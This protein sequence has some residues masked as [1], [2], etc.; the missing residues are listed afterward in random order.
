MRRAAPV[1]AAVAG[2]GIV[3]PFFVG[4][5]PSTVL[6]LLPVSAVVGAASL[7]AFRRAPAVEP[8]W[9]GRAGRVGV[10]SA[11]AHA[12]PRPPSRA[13]AGRVAAALARVE[14]RELASSP[15]F[16]TGLGFLAM[17]YLMFAVVWADDNGS[18]WADVVALAPWMA[19]PLVGMVVVAAHRGTTRARRDGADELFD[20][21][22]VEPATRTWGLLGS[23]WVPVLAYAAFCV[24]FAITITVRSPNLY[25]SI[26]SEAVALVLSAVVLCVGGVVLGVALGRWVRF[27]LAP[28]VAVVAVGLVS[29]QLATAVGAPGWTPFQQLATAPPFGGVPPLFTDPHSWAH[30]A[31]VAARTAAVAVAAVA[32]HRRDRTVAV[33]GLAACL[34]VAGAAVAATRPMP[35]S[36]AARIAGLV[37]R[38]RDHQACRP[39]GPVQVCAYHGHEELADRVVAEITPVAAALPAATPP[40]TLRQRYPGTLDELPPEVARRLPG[41]V[42]P[43]APGELDLGYAVNPTEVRIPRFLVATW[44]VGLPSEPGPDKRPEVIAGQARGVVALWLATRGLG[45]VPTRQLTSGRTSRNGNPGEGQPDAF[46]R[47][48]VWP[49]SCGTSPVVWSAQDLSAARAVVALPEAAVMTAVHRDWDRWRD[50]ATGTDEL[51]AALGLPPV[52]PFDVVQTRSEN[53]C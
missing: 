19:H 18:H 43:A 4:A 24:V 25:G 31:W 40:V 10:G 34:L 9:S 17:T 27:P 33:A 42:P 36:S 23:A 21:C 38:P 32:R 22:P 8:G 29:I 2:V 35:A 37:S 13:A 53:P 48:Y 14:G 3:A 39:A 1:L 6:F 20:T 51:L 41:G 47:G 52:G 45:P 28:V 49:E 12:G 44:A 11:E 26:G 46:D 30:L 15:W 50:P 16:G 5:G 7:A